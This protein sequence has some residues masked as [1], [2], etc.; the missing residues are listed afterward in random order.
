MAD[1][2]ADRGNQHNGNNPNGD[3]LNSDNINPNQLNNQQASFSI[4]SI[5]AFTTH[6]GHR[7][8]DPAHSTLLPPSN[9]TSSTNN[10]LGEINIPANTH[11]TGTCIVI[12]AGVC[13]VVLLILSIVGCC[14]CCMRRD[15]DTG[16]RRV[17]KYLA[18]CGMADDKPKDTASVLHYEGDDES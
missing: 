18:K 15:K 12:A 17:R 4:S 6:G 5:A 9:T 7:T 16:Q 10:T 2:P 14:V 8:L 13:I 3:S 1:F 11:G